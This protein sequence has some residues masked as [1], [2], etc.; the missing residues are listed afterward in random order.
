[1]NIL[2]INS[3]SSSIKYQLWRYPERKLLVKGLVERIGLDNAV[4]THKSDPVYRH[5]IKIND[6]I[7]GIRIILEALTD[8]EHGVLGSLSEIHAAGHRVVHGGEQFTD[9]V[10]ITPDV[11]DTIDN[12]SSLAPLHNPP[13]AAGIRAVMQNM[14]SIPNIAVFDT[15]F[16]QSMPQEAFLYAIPIKYYKEDMIRK[17]GF[18]GTSYRYLT[19]KTAD[20]LGNKPEDVNGVFCHLGNGSSICAVKNGKSVETTM[21]FTPLAGLVMGTRS[22]DIDPGVLFHMIRSGIVSNTSDLDTLLNKK[23]GLL[24]IYEKSSDMRDIED[25]LTTDENAKLAFR[26]FTHRIRLYISAYLSLTGPDSTIVF[27]GGIGENSPL[28]RDAVLC[29]LQH[30]GIK[31]N[32]ALNEK[33]PRGQWG[34]ISDADSKVKV[35]VIPTDEES[36]I[37]EDTYN[38]VAEL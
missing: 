29:D 8:P 25:N 35:L 15:A 13:N 17:Y 21:G 5:E 22:G 16:H 6:H 30:M 32:K 10:L 19:K 4:I 18:H 31:I 26:M 33:L 2:I 34:T 27:S 14:P 37:A 11:L 7:H 12:M 28:V 3:G 38:I 1:M 23:S 36:Q 20:I 9:S 24:S